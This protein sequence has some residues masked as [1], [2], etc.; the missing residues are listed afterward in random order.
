MSRPRL[1]GTTPT[2]F[3]HIG[4]CYRLEDVTQTRVG[5]LH[6][7]V[8]ILNECMDTRIDAL[9]QEDGVLLNLRVDLAR[10]APNLEGEESSVQDKDALGGLRIL[11]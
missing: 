10:P 3:K 5:A 2:I 9:R 7:D 8:D 1:P 6:E 4:T 11:T